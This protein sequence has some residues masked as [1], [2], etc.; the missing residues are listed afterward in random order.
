M[1]AL[2]EGE[3]D[4]DA[5]A[6]VLAFSG[7]EL[8]VQRTIVS[9]GKTRL[10]PKIRA[11]NRSAQH[12][13]WLV[14]RDS[15]SDGE[16]CPATLRSLLLRDPQAPGLCL[17]LAVRSLEA[18]LL[19]DRSGFARHFALGPARVPMDPEAEASPKLTLVGL[20]ARSTRRGVREGMVRGG[21]PGPEY[22]A[23]IGEFIRNDWNPAA[24]VEIAP[25]LGRAVADLQHR[26]GG[27]A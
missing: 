14:L 3:T 15:D 16:D 8:D 11:L 22:T 5:V 13:P 19:A 12:L 27:P 10:D 7:H 24:A 9:L 4:R 1:G 25:S 17:R 20:C 18:W 6:R 26:F 23:M 21:R 2:V